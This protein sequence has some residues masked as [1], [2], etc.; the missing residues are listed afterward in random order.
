MQKGG[1]II[2]LK[3]ANAGDLT[4]AMV[5]E[6]QKLTEGLIHLFVVKV[7]ADLSTTA[8]ILNSIQLLTMIFA[9]RL[10]LL[11]GRFV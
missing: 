8:C 9:P 11:F 6:I 4:E 10:L 2:K 3:Q 7:N 5:P 1:S